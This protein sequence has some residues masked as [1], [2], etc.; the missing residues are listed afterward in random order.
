MIALVAPLF[1]AY[2]GLAF[3]CVWQW[4]SEAPA[5]RIDVFSGGYFAAAPLWI[6]EYLIFLR[7]IGRDEEVRAEA[8]GAT[9]DPSTLTWLSVLPLL[10]LAAF[11]DYGHWRLT[12]A[13]EQ[14][15]LQGFGLAVWVL[16][17]AW[18]LWADVHLGRHF[19]SPVARRHVLTEGPFRIVRHPRYTGLLASRA[20]FALVFASALAWILFV[21][22]VGVVLRRIRRE[23]RHLVET[24]G[25]AY[26]AYAEGRPRL[27]PGVY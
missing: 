3:A 15:A 1:A 18:L 17:P 24:F 7:G 14:P 27:V 13:L 19:A 6:A 23:E 11:L 8:S 20:A 26:A 25:E 16:T 2:L 21:V 10:E 4:G 22:W 12:P 5:S 9:F